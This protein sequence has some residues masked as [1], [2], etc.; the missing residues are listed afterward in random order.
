[1]PKKNI[2]VTPEQYEI[3]KNLFGAKKAAGKK[4]SPKKTSPKKAKPAEKAKAAEDIPMKMSKKETI[5]MYKQ[6]LREDEKRR[7][8]R[9]QRT[10][11]DAEKR[12]LN[13]Y[14]QFIKDTIDQLQEHD[15]SVER[16]V[17]FRYA[18]RIWK[19]HKKTHM[20]K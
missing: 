18:L 1:M 19:M 11:E 13:R 8:E 14:Q 7:E 4:A 10:E 15:S 6:I 17:H 16:G 2:D 12:P 3:L 5:S 20:K 9:E